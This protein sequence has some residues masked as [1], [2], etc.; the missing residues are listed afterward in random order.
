MR[1]TRIDIEGRPGHYAILS[2]KR[3]SDQI[4]VQIL[5]PEQPNG[6]DHH[7]Q[8]D[9]RDDLWSMAECL[10]FHLGGHKGDETAIHAYF[11]VLKQFVD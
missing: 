8:A 7:V 2:R 4:H 1:I 10:Q 5:T 11:L 3:D 9:S 6:R